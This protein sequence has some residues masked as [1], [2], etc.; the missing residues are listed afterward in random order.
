MTN[1]YAEGMTADDILA[2]WEAAARAGLE[3]GQVYAPEIFAPDG[4]TVR[5]Y[6][7]GIQRRLNDGDHFTAADYRN[8]TRVAR[9]IGRICS[10][11]AS[12]DPHNVVSLDVFQGAAELA[13]LHAMCP[14]P[15]AGGGRWCEPK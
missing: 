4:P 12:A 5:G 8:S 10:I 15:K 6:R 9:D 2:A 14:P 1:E 7:R 11:M 3:P 13:R